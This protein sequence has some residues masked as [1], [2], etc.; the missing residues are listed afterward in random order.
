MPPPPFR[1]DHVGSLLRPP[2]LRRAFREHRDG[3]LGDDEFR[4]VQDDAIRRVVALQEGLGLR[5]VTDGEFRRASY[6]AHFVDAVDGIEVREALFHF[7][8]EA[9]ERMA[10]T[11]PHVSGRLRRGRPISAEEFRF[12]RAVTR[13]T[14]KITL[15]APSTL[16]FWRGPAGIEPRAY[17]DAAE[18]FADLARVYHDEIAELAKLGATYL[19]LDEVALAM[20]CDPDVRAAVGARGEDP[21]RLVDRYVGAINAALDGRPS[22]MTV[23]MH[24]CRGNYKGKWMGAGGYEAV[25]ERVFG[26]ARVDALFLEFDSPRAGDFAP[27]RHVSA[28]KRVVLGLVSSKTPVLEPEDELLRRIDRASRVVPLERLALSPQC[29]FAS[30][31]AGNPLGE[32]D[33]RRKLDLVVRLARQVW[34]EA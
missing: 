1:A 2:E 4:R 33:E 27:L 25:A 9:G 34:G 29:G 15:P 14:P 17:G 31:A 30:T 18:F 12:L 10:F 21:E 6:W 8:D 13:E 23:A 19:Q 24:L 22:D 7:R 5:S 11:A 16:H 26:G 32:D 20:L 28:D 3:R